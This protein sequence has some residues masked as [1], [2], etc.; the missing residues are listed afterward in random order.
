MKFTIVTPT[1]GA[2]AHL[3]NCVRSVRDQIPQLAASDL[4]VEHIILNGRPAER[5]QVDEACVGCGASEGYRV[6]TVHEIDTGMY[7]AIN[8]GFLRATGEVVA[9]LNSDEQYLPGALKRIAQMFGDNAGVDLWAAHTIFIDS[10]GKVLALR[11][12]VIPEANF[13]RASYLNLQS[14]SIF[15]KRKWVTAGYLMNEQYKAIA[16]AD[17]FVRLLDGGL[18][19]GIANFPVGCFM[20]TGRNLGASSL[21]IDEVRGW[22]DASGLNRTQRLAVRWRHLCREVINGA[23]LPKITCRFA[24]YIHESEPRIAKRFWFVPAVY[25]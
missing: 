15:L 5:L 9:W 21:G 16:D 4:H 18:K 1:L 6:E 24:I 25:R 11:K 13:V 19:C 2:T 3:R 8:R 23:R 20:V 7:Q 22:H 12:A 10:S 17:W 14:C